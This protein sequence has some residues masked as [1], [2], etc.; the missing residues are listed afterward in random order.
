MSYLPPNSPLF[1]AQQLE[2][3]NTNAS[4]TGEGSLIPQLPEKPIASTASMQ[5]YII[6]TEKTLFFQG[7]DANEYSERQPVMLR[8]CLFLRVLK[9]SKVKSIALSFQGHQRTDWP[10]GIPP[11][12]NV[13]AED[14]D[15]INH[16]WPFYSMSNPLNSINGGADLYSELP[17]HIDRDISHLNLNDSGNRTHSS[18]L[19]NLEALNSNSGTTGS[20]LFR[21]IGTNKKTASPGL[22][23][24]DSFPD[25][26]A[27]NTAESEIGKPGTFPPGDYIYNFEHPLHPSLPETTH[28]TFGDVDYHLEAT[29]IRAG[30]FSTNLSGKLPI[31]LVRTPSESNLEENEPI[32]ITRDW[33]D[34][35]RY[36]IVIGGKSIILDSY[37]PLAFRFVP[38][39]GKVALHRIRVYLTENLEYYCQNKKVHRMEP[40]KKYLLLEHKAKKG[41]SLLSRKDNG[42]YGDENDELLPRELEFQLFVPRTL[43]GKANHVL[44][45]DTSFEDIQS[46]HWIKLCLRISK[47]DP[48]NDN[49]RKHYEISIDSPIHVLST[50]AAHGN[51][52]LPAYDDQLPDNSFLPEYTPG[53]PPLSP[54]VTPI[55]T[56]HTMGKLFS[57]LNRSNS[58][59]SQKS[60][61]EN[62]LE[63][64][65]SNERFYRLNSSNNNDE[66]LER[67]HDMHLEANLY[68]PDLNDSRSQL[69]SPQATPHPGSFSP[70]SSPT[71]RPIHV[72]RRPSFNPPPFDADTPPPELPADVPPPAY[73]EE[74]SGSNVSSIKPNDSVNS[75]LTPLSTRSRSTTATNP[76]SNV[77]NSDISIRDLLTHS[78]SNV[79]SKRNSVVSKK[80]QSS[81]D[82][83]K[84]SKISLPERKS[85]DSS[86]KDEK[87]ETASVPSLSINDRSVLDK[88]DPLSPKMEGESEEDIVDMIGSP[89]LIPR[90]VSPR[91]GLSPVVSPLASPRNGLSP[92]ASPRKELSPMASPRNLSPQASPKPLS[93]VE[94]PKKISESLRL[95][96]DQSSVESSSRRGSIGSEMSNDLYM[97]QKIPLLSS[98][99]Q[100]LVTNFGPPNT[101]TA[102]V[103]SMLFDS[104]RRMSSTHRP[105][106]VDFMD[107][108]DLGGDYLKNNMNMKHYKAFSFGASERPNLKVDDIKEEDQN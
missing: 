28:V 106:I 16:T 38:L 79:N 78:F 1:T 41:K 23:P 48:E 73:E 107:G 35:L 71:M 22:N 76:I 24:V 105:S 33:E 21:N 17:K 42:E 5:L 95:N 97:G 53:S 20:F 9:P 52:L 26:A 88:D 14:I 15:I 8:G 61:T 36:D 89:E 11:K 34:Q 58:L 32:V 40:S 66:P 44:H 31:T 50:L 18:S 108:G 4:G 70:I 54:G 3:V 12:K 84:D 29:V 67:D 102:S 27:V 45:P 10:E 96:D 80:S 99:T 92:M 43:N 63:A 64:I 94:S 72:L 65:T 7:F 77:A 62:E 100:S 91:N 86:N 57:A 87:E 104:S 83:K 55:D 68:K 60:K 25:L 82:S 93:P 101:R 2:P 19:G 13:F 74:D 30:V 90:A 85:Y 98:S 39:W 56:T 49:K 51:T 47:I 81:N 6:P 46:H 59:S 75:N 37:L 69:T 103:G